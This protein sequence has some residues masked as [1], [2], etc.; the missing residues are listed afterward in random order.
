MNNLTNNQKMIVT[1]LLGLLIGGGSAWLWLSPSGDT[2]EGLE[3]EKMTGDTLEITGSE[4]RKEGNTPA[5]ESVGA[6][7]GGIVVAGAGSVRV[8]DQAAGNSVAVAEAELP[9]EGWVAIHDDAGGAPGNILGAKR[10]NAGSFSN[11]T[12]ELLR[13]TASQSVY[14]AVLHIDNG[15]RAFDPR[16]DV[17]ML[18]RDGVMILE[19]F[20]VQ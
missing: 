9:Q 1:F 20:N 16:V 10:E 4:A 5:L 8:A 18:D 11:I 17:P 14:F 7:N 12:V 6:S 19:K 3:S 2:T 13:G 15:D